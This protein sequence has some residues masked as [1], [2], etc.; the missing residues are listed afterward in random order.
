[1]N[2]A[3]T[4]KE[5]LEA[6]NRAYE[7]LEDRPK[8]PFCVRADDG[9]PWSSHLI[10]DDAMKHLQLA[11]K[12]FK[13]PTVTDGRGKDITAIVDDWINGEGIE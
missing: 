9:H 10:H 5:I 3:K 2:M 12:Y 13:N 4:K 11:R 6:F 8:L 7:R 1:M